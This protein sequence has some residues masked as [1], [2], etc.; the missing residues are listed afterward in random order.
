MLQSEPVAYRRDKAA[1]LGATAVIDPSA[2]D[3]AEEVRAHLPGGVDFIVDA[4][5]NPRAV[6]QAVGLLA[7]GGTL[8]VFGVC[9]EGSAARFD[10]FELYNKQARIVGSKMPPGTLNHAAALIESG[11]I[12]CDEI[13]TATLSLAEAAD[14]V[15]AFND[16]RD[17]QVKVAVDPWKTSPQGADRPGPYRPTTVTITRRVRGP[18][19]S[20]KYTPCHVPS[21]IRPSTTGT[22][23][24]QPTIELLTWAAL[25]PSP[26]R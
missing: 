23:V 2:A 26:W 21:A 16:R 15:A 14:A 4:S 24:E 25:L 13:V 18:S 22:T 17:S 6:E 5:G 9:P 8:M 3:L 20:Q 19:N 7:P 10:P 1:L 12:V 11:T